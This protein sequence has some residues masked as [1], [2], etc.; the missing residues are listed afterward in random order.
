MAEQYTKV[1]R[2]GSK[3]YY[4]DPAKTIRH[5]EDGPAVEDVDG[6]KEWWVNGVLHRLDGPAL[7]Y[8]NGHK[9]WWVNGN[10]HRLNGPAVEYTSGYQL[11]Y[12]DDIFIFAVDMDS[13]ITS[14]M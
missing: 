9:E 2:L 11:W 5:R 13:K 12:V 14:R 1:D 6:H 7:E 3:S 4:K 10:R 8:V